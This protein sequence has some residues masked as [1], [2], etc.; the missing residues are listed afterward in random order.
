MLVC[1]VMSFTS[2]LREM[3]DM[4]RSEPWDGNE[5]RHNSYH[6]GDS[7]NIRFIAIFQNNFLNYINLLAKPLYSA[8]YIVTST[9]AGIEINHWWSDHTGSGV[10]HS[11][12]GRRASAV[13]SLRAAFR[14]IYVVC[15]AWAQSIY[16]ISCRSERIHTAL[17]GSMRAPL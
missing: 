7:R 16:G 9:P 14:N 5:E 8:H 6:V 13:R 10:E 3:P 1:C 12:A 4:F 17:V 11:D 2:G 15:F